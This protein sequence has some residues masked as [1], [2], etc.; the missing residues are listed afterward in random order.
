MVKPENKEDCCGCTA[1]ASICSH[2]AISMQPDNLGF[3]YPVIDQD[4]CVQ[5]GLCDK[6]CAFN[7][8]YSKEMNLRQPDVYAVRH[9][10]IKEIEGSRSGAMF[11]V[12]SDYILDK[13]GTVYGVG[14][15]DHFRVSHKRASTKEERDE[16]RGSKYV[17]SDMNG[18]FVQVKK[19]LKQGLP[20]LFSGTP[21]QTSG[22]RSYLSLLRINMDKLCVVDIICH[23]VPGPYFWRDYLTYIEQKQKARVIG[24]NFRD[25][26]RL[27]WASHRE[28]FI[29][30]D[31]VVG[32]GT[33]ASVFC[34][35]IMFRHS[36]GVCHFANLQRPSDITIG[37]FWGY[38]RVDADFNADNKGVSLVLV[39]TRKGRMLFDGVKQFVDYITTDT[40]H[41]MQLNLQHPTAIHPQRDA[42]ERDYI[43]HGFLY[44]GRKYGD[45]GWKYK[46]NLYILAIKRMI[47]TIL[48]K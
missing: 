12:I 45:M 40:R 39:N 4:K 30:A 23:G 5:C 32:A 18:I 44:V 8:C 33:Y 37:D 22:L 38:E 26:S 2:S 19:D 24:V 16:F 14:Y 35:S 36:C 9:K 17:Q 27:G 47:K 31:G 29:F 46:T 41:C 21:C 42:F 3:L 15:T 48:Y 1:C 43:N 6:V 7:T 10:N 34:Q 11:V 28:S 20:V 25:K 13:G